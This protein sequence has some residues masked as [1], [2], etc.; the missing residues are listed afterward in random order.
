MLLMELGNDIVD[1]ENSYE[2]FTTEEMVTILRQMATV[3]VFLKGQGIVHR[4]IQPNNLLVADR[5]DDGRRITVKLMNFAFAAK[6]TIPPEAWG[7]GPDT[8]KYLAPE[9]VAGKRATYAGDVW[10]LGVSIMEYSFGLPRGD[11]SARTWHE[12][13]ESRINARR[14][15]GLG[16]VLS[17]MVR[18]DPRARITAEDCLYMAENLER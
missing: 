12:D 13:C 14:Q 10:S 6:V 18:C 9:V 1:V 2:Q 11:G 8:P 16:K 5:A 4:D 17:R 7:P 3:L 15:K